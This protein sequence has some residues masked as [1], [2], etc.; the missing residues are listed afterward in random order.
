MTENSGQIRQMSQR[1][2]REMRQV[3]QRGHR[4]ASG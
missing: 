2:H 4:L 3:P 1:G